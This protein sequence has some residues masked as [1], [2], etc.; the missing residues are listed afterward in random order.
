M[1]NWKLVYGFSLWQHTEGISQHRA[2]QDLNP[3][4]N[5]GL[6]KMCKKG[7][8][9]S[10][11][12]RLSSNTLKQYILVFSLKKGQKIIWYLDICFINEKS[13]FL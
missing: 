7:T 8:K 11:L 12:L 6:N 10:V 13:L 1:L 2:P 3:I 9:T 5:P 4:G